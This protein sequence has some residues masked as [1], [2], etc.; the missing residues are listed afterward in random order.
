MGWSG[1]VVVIRLRFYLLCVLL[2]REEELAVL[3]GLL[4]GGGAVVVEGGT[5]I[6]KTSLVVEG[7]E[8]ARGR[9]WHVL[10]GCG[11][12]LET[13]F[14]FG[15]VRQLFERELA[16]ADPHERSSPLSGD[17]KGHNEVGAFFAS[18]MELSGGTFAIG[19]QDILAQQDQVVVLGTVK[20]ERHGRSRS[21]P[22]VH[23]WR[24]TG[25]QAVDFRE[26]QGDQQVED[27]FWSS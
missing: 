20:A 15:V 1:G 26:I 5:G 3:G 25:S 16:S 13:G 21:S 27:E 12:E 2:E 24:V 4:D 9:G 10:R 23:V 22:E 19:I 8:R 14:A 18:T 17:Y 7:C 6:G 11:S